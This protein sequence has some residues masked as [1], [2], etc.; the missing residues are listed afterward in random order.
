MLNVLVALSLLRL[1]TIT[2]A[3]PGLTARADE[4]DKKY[5]FATLHSENEQ[6]ADEKTSL[7]IYSS[8]D[9]I[10]FGE[11]AMDIYHPEKGLVRDPS[12]IHYLGM[13]Y[14]SHTTGWGGRDIGIISSEDLKT[15]NPVTTINTGDWVG[16][17][18]AP[19]GV[20]IIS[21]CPFTY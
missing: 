17:A 7:N 11:Y 9:G 18:W 15:W 20:P 6:K 1:A 14:I 12:I 8:D 4:V 21:I 13:Y 5:I 3:A 2:H 10:N 19:V 16:S